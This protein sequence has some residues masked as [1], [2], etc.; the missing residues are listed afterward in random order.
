MFLHGLCGSLGV[1]ARACARL[2]A[3]IYFAT[4]YGGDVCGSRV[5]LHLS[6]RAVSGRGLAALWQA[7]KHREC[8]IWDSNMSLQQQQELESQT[9]NRS[10]DLKAKKGAD[11]LGAKT[12]LDPSGI[13]CMCV[14][15]SVCVCQYVHKTT[16]WLLSS[17]TV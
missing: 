5:S 8:V 15:V 16:V 6:T 17:P 10:E 11:V 9:V 1:C 4:L 13:L 14:C 2:C 3:S 12:E 7:D